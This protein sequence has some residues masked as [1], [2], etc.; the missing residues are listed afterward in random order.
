VTSEVGQ[1][2]SAPPAAGLSLTDIG[3]LLAMQFMWGGSFVISKI[4]V[5]EMPPLMFV[6]L[7][8]VIV[9]ALLIP[10]LRWHP[11]QMWNVAMISLFTGSLNFGLMITGLAMADD[12]APVAIMIQLGV[13]FA[14]LLSV[15]VLHER[16]GIWRIS[17]L[18]IAFSGVLVVGFDPEVFQ[19]ADALGLVITAALMMAVGTMFMRRVRG[20]PVYTMQGWLALMA[21]P[22]LIVA[23]YF[24]EGSPV[25]VLMNI[26]YDWGVIVGLIWVVLGTSLIGHAAYY[27]IMQRHEVGLTAPFM[28]L[29]PILGAAGGAYFLGDVITWRMVVGG[30][31]TLVGVLIITTREGRR[32]PPPKLAEPTL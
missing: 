23:S 12:V 8:F 4:A 13:P 22:P 15:I 32:R 14:T 3:V 16:L 1:H 10:F 11:G 5:D 9:S 31:L 18:A 17:A 2:G 25:P 30:A 26:E 6:A 27:W 24:L 29:A 28:L 21:W 19:Y 20:V 7:R